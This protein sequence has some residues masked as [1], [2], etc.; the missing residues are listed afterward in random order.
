MKLLDLFCCEGGASAGYYE[1]GFDVFGVDLFEDYS[2]NRYRFDCHRGD[3]IEFVTEHGHEFDVIH[4]S[5][6][7]QHASAGTR[8]QD[9]SRYP[10][11]IEP[12]RDALIATGKPYIIE[13]VRGSALLD[14]VELC[15]C[16]FDLKAADEDGLMLRMER[17]RLFETNWPLAAPAGHHHDPDV[18]V[19]GSYGGSRRQGDTPAARRYNAKYVR[20]GGYVPSFKVQEELMG[21]DWMTQRGLHQAL[22]PAYTEYVGR[23][24][25][26]YLE[27]G[28][29][30]QP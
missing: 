1:A 6:P 3:A 18:W 28:S 19:A 24:C 7:C 12:T 29:G 11:L 14:P 22:P 25:L 9:R 4:A 10:R 23:A 13:N 26:E 20:H 17:P 30:R 8:A 27:A 15:G 21:I 2:Q 16:M 5:P